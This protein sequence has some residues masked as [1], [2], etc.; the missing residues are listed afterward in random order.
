[1]KCNTLQKSKLNI[2]MADGVMIS[3]LGRA[4]EILGTDKIEIERD[5]ASFYATIDELITY[6]GLEEFT[7]AIMDIL[8]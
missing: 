5:G 7:Q 2:N 1:M 4:T 8:G 3:Q 6:L